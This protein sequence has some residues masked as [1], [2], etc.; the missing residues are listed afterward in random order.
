MTQQEIEALFKR[1]GIAN[2]MCLFSQ[3]STGHGNYTEERDT[4]FRDLTL[5]EILTTMTNRYH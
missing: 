1:I 2:T 4:L 3:S 5:D